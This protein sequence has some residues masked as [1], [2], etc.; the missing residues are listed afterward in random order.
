M[1]VEHAEIGRIH[2]DDFRADFLKTGADTR[3]VS[4]EIGGA[5]RTAFAVACDADIRFNGDDR[6]IEDLDE[7][8][9][10]PAVAALFERQIDLPGFDGRD[11]HRGTSLTDCLRHRRPEMDGWSSWLFYRGIG[12]KWQFI[13]MT[14]SYFSDDP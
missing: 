1:A 2:A 3:G 4:G 10:R 12:A 7:I 8:A 9:I 5:E 6:G 14:I 11:L 13:L